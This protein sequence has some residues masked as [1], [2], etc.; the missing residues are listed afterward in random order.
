LPKIAEK[1]AFIKKMNI[2]TKSS[3][4]RMYDTQTMLND[5]NSQKM[6]E[7][8]ASLLR[9]ANEAKEW[10]NNRGNSGD[11]VNIQALNACI[12]AINEQNTE[13]FVKNGVKLLSGKMH[14]TARDI[15]GEFVKF[16]IYNV[17]GKRM[18]NYEK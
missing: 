13:K 3:K 6:S 4:N 18:H 17:C 9:K 16:G 10:Y 8:S 12:D 1:Q 7:I 14:L 11:N 5:A 2:G 15:V